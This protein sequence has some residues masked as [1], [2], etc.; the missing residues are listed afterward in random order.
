MAK[1]DDLITSITTGFQNP[2]W[3]AGNAWV[4]DEQIEAYKVRRKAAGQT[5]HL[6]TYLSVGES[7]QT[8]TVFWGHKLSDCLK[9]ALEW[10]GLPTKTKRGPKQAANAQQ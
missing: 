5:H 4:A 3:Q 9:K 8:P 1:I 7:G 10:R 2:Q 6:L